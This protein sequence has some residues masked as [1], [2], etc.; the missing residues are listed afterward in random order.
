MNQ[1]TW[2]YCKVLLIHTCIL[3]SVNSFAQCPENIGFEAGTFFNWECGLGLISS[4]DGAITMDPSSPTSGRHTLI[5]NSLPLTMDPYGKFPTTCPNGSNYSVQLGNN[6]TGKGAERI[7][8]TFTIPANDN[9][10]SIIY[11][12]AVV[13]QNPG[14]LD[15]EQPKFT[16]NVFDVTTGGYIGCSSFAYTAS[17][18]LPGF[19]LSTNGDKV[20]YKPWTPVTIKL[21]GYAGRTIRLEFTTNDCSKGGHF[22]YAYLDVNQNCSSPISGSTHCFND[23][24]QLLTA[25]YG[26]ASY[27]WFNGNDLSKELQTGLTYDIKPLPAAGTVFAVEITPFPDQGCTDTVYTTIVY[28]SE[29]IDLKTPTSEVVSCVTNPIDLT[30]RNLTAGSSPGLDLS[31][32]TDPQLSNYLVG[33]TT[34]TT[35]GTYYIKAINAIGCTVM[36]PVTL[37]V[38]NFPDFKIG[39][40]PLVRRPN[41]L[42]LAS[43]ELG[44]VAGITFSYWKDSLATKPLAN[45]H[46]VDRTGRYFILATIEGGCSQM[47]PVNVNIDEAIISPP[48]AFTP[49]A[50]GVNDE[51]QIPLLASL[52]LDCTVDIYNRLG[53]PVF[54]SVGYAKPWD[55]KYKGIDQ[56]V[57]TYYY[58][59]KPRIDI[60]PV[61]GSV[62]IV[63]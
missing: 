42:D 46:S 63:R 30:S 19:S 12:Y 15:W 47:F 13:F 59:I 54:H 16:A 41:V 3:F 28:S 52:Y 53:Q 38:V 27:R 62:T 43:M 8:Y 21:S 25:P 32:F 22:G 1:R 5:K 55:G 33:P 10:Y 35:G 61:G 17:S 23:T 2:R 20:Y 57:G 51:W 31:Y 58:V 26:F 50:D 18:N 60:P 56:P 45:P 11:N 4:T 29:V 40:P 37:R 44:N 9:N 48:N 24:A 34:V 14:H 49:N 7:S 6:Q 39:P 36:K